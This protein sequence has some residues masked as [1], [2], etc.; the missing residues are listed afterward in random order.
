MTGRKSGAGQGA[1]AGRLQEFA[2]V[3]ADVAVAEDGVSGDEQVGTGSHDVGHG[4]EIDATVDF[5]AIREAARLAYAR[6]GFNLAQR[7]LDEVLSAKAGIYRHHQ[8]VMDDV[9]D[10]VER[11]DRSG[12]I[13]DYRRLAS[14]RADQVQRAVEMHAGFLMDGNPVGAGLREGLDEIVGILNHQV[15]VKR[16]AGNGFA[17]RGDYRRADRDVGDEVAIH[18]V[19]VKNRAAGVDG[20]LSLRA[21]LGEVGGEDG[22]RE[23]D[24]RALLAD[25]V[26]DSM[27]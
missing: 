1:G 24:Q 10:F 2:D 15:T 19:D 23:F 25:R 26:G 12:R 8:D 27:V 11:P 5:D 3:F 17:K 18:D 14:V 22:W 6:K 16:D 21:E 20:G 13:N 4:G 9:E 7:T